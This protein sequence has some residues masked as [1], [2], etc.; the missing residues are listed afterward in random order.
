M[1]FCT[2][3]GSRIAGRFCESCGAP[4]PGASATPV[5]QPAPVV[6]P[7]AAQGRRINPI[8]WILGG[9]AAVILL[10][11][12]ALTIGGIFVL[13]KAKQAGLDPDLWARN[14][15]VAATKLVAAA[16]PDAEVVSVDE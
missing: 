2:T 10:F 11:G 14:P 12:A 6:P 9:I 7:L 3:C 5:A 15:G 8:V 16:N 13:H 1:A 4:A